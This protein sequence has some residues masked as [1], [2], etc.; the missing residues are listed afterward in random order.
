MDQPTNRTPGPADPAA[1]DVATACRGGPSL[2]EALV[3]PAGAFRS[4][5]EVSEH[6]RFTDEEKRIVLLSWAR[7]ELALE[8]VANRSLPELRQRSRIDKVIT[9]LSRFD[10]RAACEYRGAVASIRGEASRLSGSVLRMR[11]A[12]P[13]RGCLKARRA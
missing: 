10:P 2:T 3:D 7:D 12:P 13:G 6:A 8:Q 1:V 4:P 9:E 11:G 5:A